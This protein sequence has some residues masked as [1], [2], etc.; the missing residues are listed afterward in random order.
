MGYDG[1]KKAEVDNST[2]FAPNEDELKKIEDILSK[3][4]KPEAVEIK[5]DIE[6][7]EVKKV[8]FE[9]VE[10]IVEEEPVIIEPQIV[11][12]PLVETVVEP[13]DELYDD[14]LEEI[15]EVKPEP[16]EEVKTY[17][18]LNYFK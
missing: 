18:V 14:I 11:E 12:E 17:K 8:F 1:P 4:S 15:Q 16:V 10:D 6:E 7:D 3:Y 13:T 9:P 2:E 5:E